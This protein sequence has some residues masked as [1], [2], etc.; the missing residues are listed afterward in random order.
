MPSMNDCSS[1]MGTSRL[2]GVSHE[3]PRVRIITVG[4]RFPGG[5]SRHLQVGCIGRPASQVGLY[6]RTSSAWPSA[7]SRCRATWDSAAL[8]APFLTP[9]PCLSLQVTNAIPRPR[10]TALQALCIK[11]NPRPLHRFNWTIGRRLSAT[12]SQPTWSPNPRGARAALVSVGVNSNPLSESL[13]AQSDRPSDTRRRWS[14]VVRDQV[15]EQGS[16]CD[17][18]RMSTSPPSVYE[19]IIP[20][21]HTRLE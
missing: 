15:A 11:C 9:K 18:S 3:R 10:G 13:V 7:L 20:S 6:G 5:P 2:L 21:S 14:R 19:L 12:T 4:R 17:T 16:H 1:K 8:P